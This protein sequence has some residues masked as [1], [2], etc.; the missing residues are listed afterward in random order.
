VLPTTGSG[1]LG[2]LDL[3]LLTVRMGNSAVTGGVRAVGAGRLANL[4]AARRHGSDPCPA[5]RGCGWGERDGCG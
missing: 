1:P 2:A 3:C 4:P 5:G